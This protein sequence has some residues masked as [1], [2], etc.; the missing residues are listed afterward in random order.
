METKKIK[1]ESNYTIPDLI[2]EVKK[3]KLRI[4]RFQRDYVWP[5]TKVVKLLD[6]I[7]KQYPIGSF[8]LWDAPK[9]YNDFYRDIS[10]LEIEKPDQNSDLKF[11]LDGQQRIVSL[12]VAV[13][14]MKIGSVEYSK[15]YF[16]LDTEKFYIPPR[17]VPKDEKYV[18][19][20]KIL[21]DSFEIYDRL[22][23]KHKKIFSDCKNRFIGYPLSV[24][25][26][27]DSKLDEVVEMFERVNQG[28]KP[29]TLFD[30]VV[31][32]T[33]TESFD[34][35]ERVKEANQYFEERGF[36]S[37]RSDSFTQALALILK[38]NCTNSSQLQMKTDEI[39]AIWDKLVNSFRMSV[40]F[41]T[42]NLGVKIYGFIP[43]P[44]ILSLVAYLF[45]KIDNKALS[46]DQTESLKRW[47][48]RAS[49]SERYS[50]AT[51]TR[52]GEDKKNIF[53]VVIRNQTPKIDYSVHVTVDGIK[54]IVMHRKSAIKNGVLCIMALQE[55]RHFNN[56]NVIVLDKSVCAGANNSEK[57]H[58]FPRAYVKREM[59]GKEPNLL[60]NFCLI[61]AE[62]NKNISDK[63]PSDYIKFYQGSNS[64]FT[65][66]LE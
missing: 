11:I 8:F 47:F 40:D 62:L 20:S 5:R 27:R 29:L 24:I 63:K 26:V 37:I 31:A 66:I 61:T 39:K 54:K 1:I 36:G 60:A 4:P 44:A 6:S 59:K 56:N 50:S 46:S 15:I 34:L 7:Y 53:D 35:K 23:D 30:L 17:G 45:F 18:Q 33:W 43:Y 52:M 9:E 38:D 49:F 41:I 58:I 65:N 13:K 28:G 25:Y 14:G 10:E 51:L 12:Y 48:W 32:G 19:F 55:P 64:D 3:G 57:H 22:S 21:D 16:D 42:E 2:H